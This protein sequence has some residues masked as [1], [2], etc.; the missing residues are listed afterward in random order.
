MYIVL[1]VIGDMMNSIKMGT[2]GG[3][4]LCLGFPGLTEVMKLRQWMR[5]LK[6]MKGSSEVG[7]RFKY[8]EPSCC[9]CRLPD[10]CFG[11]DMSVEMSCIG[12]ACGIQHNRTSS[13]Q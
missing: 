5:G 10:M 13:R 9:E 8:S 12:Q 6:R 4:G 7:G 2:A 11:L 3:L 1:E